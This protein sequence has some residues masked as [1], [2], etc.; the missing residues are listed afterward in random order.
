M[1]RFLVAGRDWPPAV[2]LPRLYSAIVGAPRCMRRGA[3]CDLS[4]GI[5]TNVPARTI[6]IHLSR[7]DGDL[8][9][10]LT[11]HFASVVPAD[12]PDR[13]TRGLHAPGYRAVS[14]RRVGRP[15]RRDVRAQPLLPI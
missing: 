8:L 4:R 9:H 12:S 11:M 7:P 13:P 6:T 1:E 2:G 14:P 5:E 15:A 3:R 10:K